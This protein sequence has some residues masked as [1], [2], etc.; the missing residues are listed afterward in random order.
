[1]V[2]FLETTRFVAAVIPGLEP[3][4]I[5]AVREMLVGVALILVLRLTPQGV[6]PERIPKAPRTS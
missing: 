5:A 1:M 6:L 2:V 3:V 4:Q